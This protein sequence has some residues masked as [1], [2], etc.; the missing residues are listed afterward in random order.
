MAHADDMHSPV[1]NMLHDG[2][3][4]VGKLD[5]RHQ[6]CVFR[7]PPGHQLVFLQLSLSVPEPR[8]LKPMKKKELAKLAGASEQ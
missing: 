5:N 1:P 6:S 7:H 2:L 3:Q 8:K 4:L